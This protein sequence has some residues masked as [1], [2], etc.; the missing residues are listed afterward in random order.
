M[1]VCGCV[2]IVGFP[3][4]TSGKEPAQQPTE[5]TGN[6][7]SIPGLERSLGEGNG[8]LFRYPCLEKSVD[9]RAWQTTLSTGSQRVHYD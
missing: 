1:C 4:G 6:T 3:G 2:F 8:N 9:S 5:D 7:G